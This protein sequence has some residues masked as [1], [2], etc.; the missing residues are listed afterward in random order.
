MVNVK[1][2]NL[3][4]KGVGGNKKDAGHFVR[5]ASQTRAGS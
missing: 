4:K 3:Y 2:L 1:Y 5:L